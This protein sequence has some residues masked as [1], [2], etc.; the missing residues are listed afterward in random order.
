MS[1]KTRLIAIIC[2]VAGFYLGAESFTVIDEEY[3][4]AGRTRKET[5]AGL[6]GNVRGTRFETREELEAFVGARAKKIENLRAFKSSKIDVA[7]G[8]ISPEKD[9]P[10][11]LKIS[12]EDG[13]AISPIP[14]AF[15]NSNDGIQIGLLVN[16]PNVAGTLEDLMFVAM[17]A[18]PPDKE[19]KLQ[20]TNPNFCVMGNWAGIRLEPFTVGFSAVALKMNRDVVNRGVTEASYNEVRFSGTGSVG[21]QIAERLTDTAYVSV[22][23]SPTSTLDTVR[24]ENY[25]SYGPIANQWAVRNDLTWKGFDWE[26]NFR[27]GCRA[28]ATVTYN[29]TNPRYA[30]LTQ[31]LQGEAEFAAYAILADRFNP[32]VRVGGFANTGNP[33][34]DAGSYARGIRNAGM[35]GN[36]GAFLNTGIQTKLFRVKD[37]EVHLSPTADLA[38]TYV[39]SDPDYRDEWGAGVGCELLFV[40]DSMKNLPLKLGFAYDLR[41]ESRLH[42]GKRFEVDFNFTLT[43]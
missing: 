38:W 14:Y 25:L 28:N 4:I 7:Y 27:E 23:G 43:Y 24:D 3:E 31:N 35:K 18:A 1:F 16:A 2:V 10:V 6:L 32:S 34:L 22:G 21:Y 40:A 5:L 8:E 15:Y 19:D 37:A 26:G 33:I 20:W 42:G 12:I 11:T 36:V 41:P 29:R 17:Y 13:A 9:V 30:A 39:Y